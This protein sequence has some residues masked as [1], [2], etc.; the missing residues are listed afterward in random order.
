MSD[1]WGARRAAI[2]LVGGASRRMQRS[3]PTLPFAGRSLVEHVADRL[4]R[5]VPLIVVVRAP[6]QPEPISGPDVIHATDAIAA[7]GPLIGLRAGLHALTQRA[8]RAF[9]CAVDLPF[10]APALVT[11][12]LDLL[13]DHEVVMPVTDHAHP[14]CAAYRVS[15]MPAIDRLIAAGER[16]AQALLLATDALALDAA[17]LR[18]FDAD[19]ASFINL[20]TPADYAAACQRWERRPC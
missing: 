3:K 10:I 18:T 4:R 20:N 1:A 6:G 5:A 17:Q 13:D 14:L 16:R 11:H 12:L 2:M 9:V 19:L 15:V 8:G 7:G